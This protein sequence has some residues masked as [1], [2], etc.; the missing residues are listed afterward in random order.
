M[1]FRVRLR[2]W[3]VVQSKRCATNHYSSLEEKLKDKLKSN[4]NWLTLQCVCAITPVM[5]LADIGEFSRSYNHRLI[6]TSRA[7]P[8]HEQQQLMILYW[9]LR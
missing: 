7:E 6:I 1:A 9:H 2:L 5:F 4:S 3:F 8:T